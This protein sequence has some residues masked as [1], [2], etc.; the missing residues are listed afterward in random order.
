METTWGNY[1]LGKNYQLK[2]CAHFIYFG[3][4]ELSDFWGCEYA[5]L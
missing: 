3:A 1:R 4:F 2:F 5:E